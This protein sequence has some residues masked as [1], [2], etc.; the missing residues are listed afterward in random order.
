MD[1]V[2]SSYGWKWGQKSELARRAGISPQYLSDILNCRARASRELAEKLE[3]VSN[4]MKIFIE[5]A[6]FMNPQEAPEDK[7][8]V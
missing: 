5:K 8:I 4:E 6:H 3:K 2:E 1:Q 7:F